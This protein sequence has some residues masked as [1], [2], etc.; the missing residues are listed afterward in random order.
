MAKSKIQEKH[1]LSVQGFL[2]IDQVSGRMAI[3]VEEIGI[4]QLDELLEG[5][6]GSDIKLSISLATDIT[7]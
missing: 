3:E 5:F 4:K 1:T 2:N 7:E 6:N